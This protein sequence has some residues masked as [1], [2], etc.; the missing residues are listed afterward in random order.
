MNK[1]RLGAGVPA[2]AAS[3]IRHSNARNERRKMFYLDL[4]LRK[5]QVFVLKILFGRSNKS[6]FS[7]KSDLSLRDK[8][9]FDDSLRKSSL[10]LFILPI[11]V[12]F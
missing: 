12:V 11:H 7:Q 9:K 4:D 6:D 8:T 1:T 3:A 10:I 2:H 5:E